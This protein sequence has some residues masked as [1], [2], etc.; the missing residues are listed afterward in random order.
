VI[1]FRGRLVDTGHDR[2]AVDFPADLMARPERAHLL[3][4][5][6]KALS[7]HGAE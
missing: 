7:E 1:T 3:L 4:Q 2:C 5:G 6:M